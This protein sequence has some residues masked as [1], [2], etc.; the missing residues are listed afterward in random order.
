M[1]NE[2]YS[3]ETAASPAAPCHAPVGPRSRAASV[4]PGLKGHP[5]AARGNAQGPQ[6]QPSSSFSS[7]ARRAAREHLRHTIENPASTIET[8]IPVSHE[9][10]QNKKPLSAP[11]SGRALALFGRFSLQTDAISH[12]IVKYGGRVLYPQYASLRWPCAI[13]FPLPTIPTQHPKFAKK[14]V[15]PRNLRSKPHHSHTNSHS[16]VITRRRLPMMAVR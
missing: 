10:T 15:F 11:H 1:K 16:I 8:A 6:T 2:L 14:P 13:T 5:I 3:F 4:S 7:E 9:K 12:K